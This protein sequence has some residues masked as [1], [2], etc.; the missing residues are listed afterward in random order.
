MHFR[1]HKIFKTFLVLLLI[2]L[3]GLQFKNIM[4]Y[5]YPLKYNNVIAKYSNEYDLDPYLVSAV[6]NVESHY[7][8]GAVSS[9]NAM[10]LMQITPS[11]GRWAAKNMGIPNFKDDM[12]FNPEINIRIGCWYLNYLKNIFNSSSSDIKTV[13]AAYNSGSSN[14]SKW[15]KDSNLSQ[16]GSVLDEIPFKETENYVHKV[17]ADYRIYKLLYHEF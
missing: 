10:G 2:L 12:L 14:V 16:S 7:R 11:T 1:R 3:L 4:G 6:I 15:L 5:F 8:A 9:Q 17:T 13:L